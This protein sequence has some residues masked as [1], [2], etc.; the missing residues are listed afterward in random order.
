MQCMYSV[1]LCMRSTGDLGSRSYKPQDVVVGE[2]WWDVINLK[3]VTKE[4]EG[5]FYKAI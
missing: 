1:G 2:N 5:K 3:N 4:I